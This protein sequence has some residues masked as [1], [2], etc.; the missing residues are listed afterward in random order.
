M[1]MNEE[2]PEAVRRAA[3]EL[4]HQSDDPVRWSRLRASI[5]ER[6]SQRP[7]SVPELLS[8]W[9]RLALAPLIAAALIAVTTTLIVQQDSGDLG[10]RAELVALQ[11]ETL[12]PH[13]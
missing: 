12:V 8:Q 4:R 9:L 13:E 1:S 10:T 2:F 6:V 3:R 11:S 7:E 5:M